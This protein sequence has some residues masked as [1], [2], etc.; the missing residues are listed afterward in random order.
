MLTW[1]H[2]RHNG[3]VAGTSPEHKQNTLY[4]GEMVVD[5]GVIVIQHWV[6]STTDPLRC[7][8]RPRNLLRR[9][10]CERP[11][12][13]QRPR[14]GSPQRHVFVHFESCSARSA[15]STKEALRSVI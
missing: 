5:M 11:G 3:Y 10:P 7:C 12:H 1:P 13:F 2:S 4:V 8:P 15:C 6:L 14:D 9:W